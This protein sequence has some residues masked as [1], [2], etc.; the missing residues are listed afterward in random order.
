MHDPLADPHEA[1]EEYG[2]QLYSD[3]KKIPAVDVV[4]LGVAHDSYRELS[5]K[6]LATMCN[7]GERA[8]V[9][10]D[11]RGLWTHELAKKAGFHYWRL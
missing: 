6:K 7:R 1:K 11:V 9:L 2:L 5:L 8:P 4:I 10:I 3:L